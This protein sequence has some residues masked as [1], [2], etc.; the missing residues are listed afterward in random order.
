[1]ICACVEDHDFTPA[2][3]EL[4]AKAIWEEAYS[5]QGSAKWEQLVEADTEPAVGNVALTRK[6][7]L[8]ALSAVGSI[9]RDDGVHGEDTYFQG[10]QE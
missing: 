5:A 6:A 9:V 8:A 1:M 10:M 7:A 2:D 4:A 3:V